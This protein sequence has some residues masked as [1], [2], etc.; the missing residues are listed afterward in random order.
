MKCKQCAAEVVA[1]SV[2]CHACGASLAATADPPA[3]PPRGG[4]S[5]P[6]SQ[7][8]FAQGLSA[9]GDPEDA[10]QLLWQGRFS[11]LAMISAWIWGGVVT[12]A[13][14]V[15]MAM[16]DFTG[17]EWLWLAIAALW[18]VLVLRLVYHQLSTRYS[19]TNQ[20][21]IHEHGLLWRRTDR[22]EAIDIDDITFDQGPIE[23]LLG[24]G[25][26]RI[27]SSDQSTPK[28]ALVGI[29]DVRRIATLIDEIRRKERRKRAV[30]IESI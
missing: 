29:E 26:V 16:F 11:K 14:F 4:E 24:I 12:I 17:E 5:K 21:L 18:I 6:S 3:A 2:F 19:L 28:F 8:R 22:I 13:L 30:H 9:G 23:R 10:E 27:T 25:T 7:E 20:R 1:G 15:V